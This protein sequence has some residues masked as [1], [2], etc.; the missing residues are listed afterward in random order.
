MKLSNMVYV[1][2]ITNKNMI[3]KENSEH[4]KYILLLEI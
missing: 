1:L 4:N 2:N 3:L